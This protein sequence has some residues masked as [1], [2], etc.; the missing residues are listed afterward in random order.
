MRWAFAFVLTLLLEMP[1]YAFALRRP[2]GGTGRALAVGAA[3]NLATH[4]MAWTLAVGALLPYY[5]IEGGVVVLEAA[6]LFAAARAY[7]RRLP[8]H[9]SFLIALAAN[10]LSAGV[11]L[12]IL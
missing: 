4:P 3:V 8:A 12:L 6:L 10:A 5:A 9:E 2:L 1:V 11:G 7:G